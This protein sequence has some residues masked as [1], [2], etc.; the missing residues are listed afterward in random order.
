MALRGRRAERVDVGLL[1][2][3][4]ADWVQDDTHLEVRLEMRK[5]VG[6]AIDIYW[7]SQLG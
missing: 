7:Q 6:E 3:T 2:K 1:E 4:P 5:E